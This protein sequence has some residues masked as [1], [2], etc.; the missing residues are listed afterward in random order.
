MLMRQS[1]TAQ[2]VHYLHSCTLHLYLLGHAHMPNMCAPCAWQANVLL[3]K[4]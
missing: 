3:L 1:I 2:A 4:G